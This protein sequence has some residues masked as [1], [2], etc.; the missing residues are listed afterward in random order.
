MRG[1]DF[2]KEKAGWIIILLIQ[3]L[4][5]ALIGTALGVHAFFGGSTVFL[6]MVVL[7]VM[8]VC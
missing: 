4:L 3:M 5:V 2:L 7:T 8:W 6:E 1:R